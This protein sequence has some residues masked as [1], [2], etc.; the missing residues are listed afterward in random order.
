MHFKETLRI[1]PSLDWARAGMVETLKARNF[2]YRWLLQYFFFMARLQPQGAGWAIVI[3]G[4][5]AYQYA[6]STAQ[7]NP[8][9]AR[10][11]GR[12]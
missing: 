2:I 8:T 9:L 3:G 12:L 5:F 6:L 10:G 1:N 7:N 4:Y 11:S